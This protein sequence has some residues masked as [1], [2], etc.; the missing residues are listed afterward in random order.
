[1]GTWFQDYIEQFKELWS[2]LN[3]RAKVVIIS[4]VGVDLLTLILIIAMGSSPDYQPLFSNLNPRDADAIIEKLDEQGIPYRLT[5]NGQTILV[6]SQHVYKT[7]LDMAGEGLPSQGVVGF[8]I[9][10]QSNFGT[11]DFE[12]KVNFYRALGGE[13]SR[14]IQ[15]MEA[16]EYAKVQ[17]TA[18]KESLFIEEEQPAEA[19]VLLKFVPGHKLSPDQ[20]KAISNLVASSVQGLDPDK[21]T[22]VDTSGNLLSRNTDKDFYN[23][24]LTMN[25]FEIQ[26][27][28]AESLEND[29]R[30]FLFKVLGPDN[31]TVQVKAWLNF[32]KRQVESKTYSPVVGDEG[33]VRSQ[34]EHEESYEGE[35]PVATG[36]P[37]TTSNI[38]QYQ[39]VEEENSGGT[40]ES[41]DVIT[42]YEINEK[43]EKHVYSP[44]S[45]ERLSVAVIVNSSLERD[46]LQKIRNAVQAAIGYDPE[47]GDMVT[48][49]SMDFDETLKQQVAQAQSSALQAQ[50]TRMYIYGG[51]IVLILII[52]SILLLSFKRSKESEEDMVGKAIDYMVG[53]EAEEEMAAT[54]LTE[55]EKKRQ[56]MKTEI[57]ELVNEKPDEVAQILKSWLLED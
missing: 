19:S 17:I 8:E 15:A 39:S 46:E 43:I 34:Q 52:L 11:T 22:I 23:S 20:V 4:G 44:G 13:L 42:N 36:V 27:K 51:L 12:R 28:F 30:A 16:I 6:P 56:K 41:S 2:N 10:N 3:K 37:G 9:F 47:R 53:E 21:V 29:L 55:E 33:I 24:Q 49:T 1:M 40:Y 45:V 31:F 7:R 57:A 50:K 38:P 18:P 35:N 32:D 26:R 5:D 14:S 25:Q 48:V 54:E